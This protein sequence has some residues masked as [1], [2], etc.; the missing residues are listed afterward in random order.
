MISL[1]TKELDAIVVLAKEKTYDFVFQYYIDNQIN[2]D[3]LKYIF[4]KLGNPLPESFDDLY[5]DEKKRYYSHTYHTYKFT[6]KGPI[7]VEYE[8]FNKPY[9]DNLCKIS[10]RSKSNTLKLIDYVRKINN[11]PIIFLSMKYIKLK[12]LSYAYTHGWLDY[13]GDNI[14]TLYDFYMMVAYDKN[15]KTKKIYSSL[16]DFFKDIKY[17]NLDV[18]DSFFNF[19]F[20]IEALLSKMNKKVANTI[21]I[22]FLVYRPDYIDDNEYNKTIENTRTLINKHRSSIDDDMLKEIANYYKGKEDI[23]LNLPPNGYRAIYYSI[24][25]EVSPDE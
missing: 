11:Y 7:P 5:D 23:I 14:K 22:K 3:E 13:A 6:D 8:V 21:R 12:N 17:F 24:I 4:E 16:K 18:D 15:I 9:F 25:G 20:N 2:D 1:N 10:E 19:C